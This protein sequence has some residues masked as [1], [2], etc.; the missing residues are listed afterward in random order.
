MEGRRDEGDTEVEMVGKK[1]FLHDTFDAM[2]DIIAMAVTGLFVSIV[3]IHLRSSD[4]ATWGDVVIFAT[5]TMGMYGIFGYRGF[6]G[7]V[8]GLFA[9]EI[10]T[11]GM[12]IADGCIGSD[13]RNTIFVKMLWK[14]LGYP[15]CDM[16][17]RES[18]CGL[19]P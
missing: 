17:C 18:K 12:A 10:A 2:V 13:I 6:M 1:R 5:V 15:D 7:A 16:H 11:A 14:Y 3:Y 19:I 9:C 8:I 4:I